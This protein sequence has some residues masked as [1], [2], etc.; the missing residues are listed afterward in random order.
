MTYDEMQTRCVFP[1]LH[2]GIRLLNRAISGLHRNPLMMA[3]SGHQDLTLPAALG[4][5]RQGGFATL[6]PLV[7]DLV[8][9]LLDI[10]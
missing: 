1:Y 3:A 5:K 7:C 4:L 6:Y 2:V 8:P 9:F 10:C